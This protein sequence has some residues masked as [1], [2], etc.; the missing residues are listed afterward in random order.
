[1]PWLQ[2]NCSIGYV[3]STVWFSLFF[4][5]N[6]LSFWFE[7][8]TVESIM[9]ELIRNENNVNV[10]SINIV[11]QCPRKGYMLIHI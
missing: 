7:R 6:G 3:L 4:D 9:V 5:I 1:M 10:H 11:T 2:D 8:P